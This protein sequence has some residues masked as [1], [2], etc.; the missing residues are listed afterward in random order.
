M[1]S[2]GYGVIGSGSGGGVYGTIRTNKMLT[3][4]YHWPYR[5]ET[6][7]AKIEKAWVPD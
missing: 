5:S 6:E 2:A 1:Q 7:K 4:Y 3:P